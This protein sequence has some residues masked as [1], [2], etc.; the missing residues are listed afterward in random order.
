MSSIHAQTAREIRKILKKEFSKTKFS[1]ISESFSMGN[2]VRVSWV[3][4][5]TKK[6][7]E[8]LIEC[9]QEGSF[10]GMQDMY[11]YNNSNPKIPQVKYISTHREI[12][13]EFRWAISEAK[14]M[15]RK[16]GDLGSDEEVA[17]WRIANKIDWSDKGHIETAE[18][19]FNRK[20]EE[21]Q[22]QN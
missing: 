9:F 14:K 2:A 11:V 6:Q 15:Y 4:G 22:W 3:D 20:E 13:E 12:S 10:D 21:K 1:V 5:P 17:I 18:E 8:E 7:I 19:E 16:T